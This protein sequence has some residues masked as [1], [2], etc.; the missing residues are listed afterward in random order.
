MELNYPLE[1]HFLVHLFPINIV[2]YTSASINWR[3]PRLSICC[4][5][6]WFLL[7][8]QT[9]IAAMTALRLAM[10]IYVYTSIVQVAAREEVPPILSA[11]YIYICMGCHRGL[12]KHFGCSDEMVMMNVHTFK[13]KRKFFH[14]VCIVC[15]IERERGD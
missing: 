3:R 10:Y 8:D 2:L 7:D 1:M 5:W 4:P 14:W 12:E 15:W 6:A 13:S 9:G 11:H